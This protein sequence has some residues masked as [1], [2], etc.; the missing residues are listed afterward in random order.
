MDQLEQVSSL[1]F[2]RMFGGF[3]LYSEERF[4]GIIH[5]RRLYFRTPDETR[6]AYEKAGMSV[7]QPSAKQSLKS[8]YEVQ[9]G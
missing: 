6:R 1:R 9:S 7:F 5:Q 3:G 8:Y 2:Q 4:F